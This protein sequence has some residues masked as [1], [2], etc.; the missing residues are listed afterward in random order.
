[1]KRKTPWI[2]AAAV[3]FGVLTSGACS[4]RKTADDESESAAAVKNHEAPVDIAGFCKA[5]DP[6]IN[7]ARLHRNPEAFLFQK[8]CLYGKVGR[9]GQP[10][11]GR[12]TYL[13]KTDYRDVLVS[14]FDP[15]AA[16]PFFEVG[17]NV[18]CAGYPAPVRAHGEFFDFLPHVHCEFMHSRDMDENDYKPAHTGRLE[19]HGWRMNAAKKEGD[20][21]YEIWTDPSIKYFAALKLDKE[22][23]RWAELRFV[24]PEDESDTDIGSRLHS[25]RLFLTAVFNGKV[26]AKIRDWVEKVIISSNLDKQVEESGHPGGKNVSLRHYSYT[27]EWILTVS[28]QVKRLSHTP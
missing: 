11:R 24:Y 17:D 14:H 28:R 7:S 9:L 15:N 18:I 25:C 20:L 27:D 19:S 12:S 4:C 5:A 23:V 1:V 6:R 2:A 13:L 21:L 3:L 8:V 16:K 26:A 10:E 22:G